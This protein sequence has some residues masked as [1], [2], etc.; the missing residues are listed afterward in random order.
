MRGAV[1]GADA[2]CRQH[3]ERLPRQDR[4]G[5]E[6]AVLGLLAGFLRGSFS[7]S[8][9][10]VDI[11][12]FPAVGGISF[13]LARLFYRQNPT[14]QMSTTAVA[15]FIVVFVHTVY[16]NNLTGNEISVFSMLLGSWK[17]FLATIIT[18]PFMFA[19]LRMALHLEN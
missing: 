14:V 1:R 4:G 16:F 5:G 17:Q 18:V 11:F 6:G 19:G 9:I 12:L 2:D 3:D 7:G 10:A 13:L 8:T 15:F